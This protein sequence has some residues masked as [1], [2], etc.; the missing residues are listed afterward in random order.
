MRCSSIFEE[1]MI[2]NESIHSISQQNILDVP[3]Q[4]HILSRHA[5]SSRPNTILILYIAHSGQPSSMP[6]SFTS[7]IRKVFKRKMTANPT[8]LITGVTRGKETLI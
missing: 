6:Y 5:F 2:R 1:N 8:Y 3:V 4:R 7:S